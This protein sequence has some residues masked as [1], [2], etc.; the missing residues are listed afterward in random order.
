M[1]DAV[2]LKAGNKAAIERMTQKGRKRESRMEGKEEARGSWFD[3]KSIYFTLSP[4]LLS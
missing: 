2:P 1:A 3:N 4:V